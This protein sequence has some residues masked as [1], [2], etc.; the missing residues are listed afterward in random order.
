[1]TIYQ[2]YTYLIGWSEHKKYYYGVR[3]AEGCD[4]N[5]LWETYF[6]SSKYV[7]DFRYKNGEPDIIQV[8]KTFT[9]SNK[10]IE[11]EHKVLHRMNASAREDFINKQ[12]GSGYIGA[13]NDPE[14]RKQKSDKLKDY[15]TDERKQKKSAAMVEYN[16]MHG[17]ERYIKA[18]NK[19][20]ANTDFVEQ[21]TCTMTDVNKCTVK[22][23]K[24]GRKIKELWQTPDFLE[25]MKNR[26]GG[27]KKISVT[28]NGVTYKSLS[29]AVNETGLSYH[30]VRKE[31]GL[32]K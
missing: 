20:Y 16:K 29:E 4:P 25:K 11:W 15:W 31:A 19:R 10:A 9:D 12:N 21:F 24:A 1:M 30:T 18:A 6:T 17:K 28:I 23:E 22:R 8:R 13:P 14:M 2:P 7:K 26:G 27:R 3:Y 32:V 5:D